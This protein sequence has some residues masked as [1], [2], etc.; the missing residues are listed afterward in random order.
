[1]LNKQLEDAEEERVHLQLQINNLW[2]KLKEKNNTSKSII[3]EEI[4]LEG[5]HIENE[6]DKE[7]NFSEKIN[8]IP[9]KP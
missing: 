6:N 5:T 4:S 1:M 3:T 7:Y 8:V 2:R 9:N